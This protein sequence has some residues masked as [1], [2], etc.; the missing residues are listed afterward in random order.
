MQL[1]EAIDPDHIFGSIDTQVRPDIVPAVT[2]KAR[3]TIGGFSMLSTSSLPRSLR[4][5]RV[6]RLRL[7]PL[8][9]GAVLAVVLG[10]SVAHAGQLTLTWVD[11]SGGLAAFN[12]ERK[13]GT[14]GTYAWIAQ[15]EAGV[16]SYVDGTLASGTIYCYR[17]QAF[18]GAGTSG[19]SNEACAGT[20]VSPSPV[21]P[22][23]SPAPVAPAQS[24]VVHVWF[25]NGT[26][27]IGVG[28]VAT[29]APEWSIQGSGDF[30]GD[31]K[32][33][34]LWRHS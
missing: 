34:I 25:M 15:Q 9:A 31:G 18:N 13:T 21:T 10:T 23:P 24:G 5:R 2:N 14:S 3:T 29:V 16:V 32:A 22:S 30:N 6:R 26:S 19:Y 20:A 1:P 4:Q 12:I 33:D 11:N 8:F 7:A 27:A 28:A 17:V